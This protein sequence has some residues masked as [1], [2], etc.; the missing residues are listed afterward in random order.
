MNK[1]IIK[2]EL[3]G[4][5]NEKHEE[6]IELV[7]ERL[8]TLNDFKKEVSFLKDPKRF[9]ERAV[10]KLKIK[11]PLPILKKIHYLVK[12]NDDGFN[13]KTPLFEWAKS[14]NI[15]LGFIMQ[16]LRLCL[17]GDLTGPDL[18]DVCSLLGKDVILKRV[19]NFIN[20]IK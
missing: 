20:H 13:I 17:F 10:E 6:I 2:C 11:N 9:D 4:W 8:Y 7:K 18:F 15:P 3:D 12:N 19:E 16:S 14:G 1:N 5:P